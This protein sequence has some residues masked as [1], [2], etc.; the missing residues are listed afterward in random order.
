MQFSEAIL[1]MC[2][3]FQLLAHP[4]KDNK[5]MILGG[6]KDPFLD[7]NKKMQAT[8]TK[9]YLNDYE[10]EFYEMILNYK[11]YFK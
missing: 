11:N 5:I 3:S 1:V 4:G 8:P 10:K 6:E 2:N 7:I 9:D